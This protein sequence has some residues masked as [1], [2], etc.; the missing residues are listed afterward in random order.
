M[1]TLAV[2]RGLLL[3]LPAR[4]RTQDHSNGFGRNCRAYSGRL[5]SSGLRSS[6]GH[7]R[8]RGCFK[9]PR[10]GANTISDLIAPTLVSEPT[11][12]PSFAPRRSGRASSWWTIHRDT[13]G[14]GHGLSCPLGETPPS[15]TTCGLAHCP[16][17]RRDRIQT[18]RQAEPAQNRE[19]NSQDPAGAGQDARIGHS[20]GPTGKE[21]RRNPKHTQSKDWQA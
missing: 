15:R 13:G 11:R 18:S 8:P 17:A 4:R 21:H 19:E 10:S 2:V 1:G 20:G 3:S 5:S 16:E 14:Q 6:A 12:A 9:V 7:W